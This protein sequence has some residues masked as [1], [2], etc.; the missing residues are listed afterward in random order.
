MPRVAMCTRTLEVTQANYLVNSLYLVNY[1]VNSFDPLRH[2][3]IP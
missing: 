3:G 2:P 1:L